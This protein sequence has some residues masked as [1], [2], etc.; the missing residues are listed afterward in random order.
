MALFGIFFFF[1]L[2]L[3]TDFIGAL[4]AVGLLGVSIPPET[5]VLV[6]FFSPAVLL[7][8]RR[9]L[10]VSGLFILGAAVLLSGAVEG[11]L[12]TRSR[13]LIAGVGVGL[14]LVFFPALISHLS[15][16]NRQMAASTM[17]L[18]L[19]LATAARI[20]FQAWNSGV[21]PSGSW[22]ATAA[23]WLLA[24]LGSA[25]LP[26]AL[27]SP[28]RS[29]PQ[30]AQASFWRLAGLA[31]GILAALC[32]VYFAFGSP[33]V[34]ACWAD[35][36]YPLLLAL[37]SLALAA[38][39]AL[40]LIQANG[41][42]RLSARLIVGWNVLFVAALILAIL[43]YQ[44]RFILDLSAYPWFEPQMNAGLSF[45]AQL[46]LYAAVF[47]APVILLDFSLF[48]RE[49]F[50]SGASIRRLGGAFLLAS[51]FLLVVIFAQVLTTIYDYMPVVGP[52]FRDRFW[53]VFLIVGLALGLP[54]LL[55]RQKSSEIATLPAAAPVIS[56]ALIGLAALGGALLTAERPSPPVEAQASLRVLTY[57]IQQGYDAEG[58]KSETELLELL[59]QVDADVIGLQESD[60]ARISGSNADL[61]RYLA[62]G[63]NLYSYYGPKTVTG[64]FGIAIL[65]KYPLQNPR[66]FYLYS[67]GEQ[68][69][70]IQAEI[71]AASATWQVFVTHLGN[72]GPIEQQENVLQAVDELEP[73]ILMGDFNF[74]PDTEQY[75][76][77]T[78]VLDDAWLVKW[79]DGTDDTGYNPARRIDH[80]FVSRGVQVLDARHLTGPESDHPGV[81]IMVQP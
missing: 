6:L 34:M 48:M 50:N 74:R 54:I 15:T 28:A 13:M 32:L 5:A 30:Q 58:Q 61:V 23:V 38:G 1:F 72:G 57:N 2:H 63:L 39:A 36:S 70:A 69:A 77:T 18:G 52:L 3:L 80:I 7:F 66:T 68:T 78:S 37:Q 24:L 53:L 81:L 35:A 29:A 43:P 49:I 33:Q 31:T 46:L 20:L 16:G 4:Y 47:L 14:S 12:P 44:I 41:R 64:T 19:A 62:D 67:L 59:K 11:M 22:A 73:V 56:V 60:T 21:E 71:D 8:A 51:L 75:G 42:M 65:S 26:G 25:L 10:T 45:A 27:Q 76:L 17:G 79:P 9:K 40:I 55:V